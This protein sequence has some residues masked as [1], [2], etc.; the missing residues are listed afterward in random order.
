MDWGL[1]KRLGLKTE[2]LERTIKAK[3]LNEND[4]FTITH[5]TEP[6]EL[7]RHDHQESMTFFLFNSSG[8]ALILGFP[9]LLRH[10]PHIDWRSG[11]IMGWGKDFES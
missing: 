9:W 5:A 6:V 7:H 4:L 8:H 10:N 11:E 3:D 2:L 1:A